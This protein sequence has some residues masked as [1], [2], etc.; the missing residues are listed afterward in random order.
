MNLKTQSLDIITHFN[1]IA[2]YAV[3]LNKDV[4]FN[5]ITGGIVTAC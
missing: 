3:N 5:S 2:I 1:S 4:L